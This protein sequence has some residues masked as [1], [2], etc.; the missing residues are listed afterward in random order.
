M[1]IALS[2]LQDQRDAAARAAISPI[3]SARMSDGRMVVYK[4][5]AD[6]ERAVAFADAEIAKATGGISGNRVSLAQH[7]RGDGPSGPGFPFWP[8]T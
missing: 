6:A 2:E 4:S 7:R 3:F 8:W 5:Q 1:A